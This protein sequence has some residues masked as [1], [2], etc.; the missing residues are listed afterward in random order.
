MLDINLEIGSI[1]YKR[2]VEAMLPPLVRHC[3]EK[4]APNTLDFFLAGLG[5]YAAPAACEM[6]D[7]M[8]ADSKDRTVVWLVSAH[9]ERMRSSA[10]RHLAEVLGGE[11]IRI[12]RLVAEDRPGSRLAL[13][14]AQVEVDYNALLTSPLVGDSVDRLGAEHG[15]LK[16]AAKLVISMGGLFSAETLEKQSIALLGTGMVREKLKKLLE[17]TL[18]QAGLEVTIEDIAAGPARPASEYGAQ[19]VPAAFEEKLLRELGEKARLMRER[20]R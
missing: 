19:S 7:G 17:D 10:N 8:D 20:E 6:L 5:E 14:A 2:C 12:G 9:E 18:R 13:T 16:G 4:T 11:M 15:I 1:D 3:A